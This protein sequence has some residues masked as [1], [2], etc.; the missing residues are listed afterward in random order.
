[1]KVEVD[2]ASGV[3][4]LVVALRYEAD[5]PAKSDARSERAAAAA[6]AAAAVAAG[7]ASKAKAAAGAREKE[8]EKERAKEREPEIDADSSLDAEAVSDQPGDV[9]DNEESAK[10]GL[11]KVSAGAAAA[12]KKA[13]GKVGPAITGLGASVKGGIARLMDAVKKRREDRAEQ[14]KKD[15]PRRMTAPPP[16]GAL[17]ADGKRLVRDDMDDDESMTPPPAKKNKKAALVGSGLGLLAVLVVF[18]ITRFVAMRNA[19]PAEPLAQNSAPALPAPGATDNSPVA[20]A[21][22][23][24]FGQTPLST[25]EPVPTAAPSGSADANEPA[26]T[27]GNEEPGNGDDGEEGGGDKAEGTKEWGEG[28]VKSPTKISVKLDGAVEGFNGAKGAMG[29]TIVLP[30]RRILSNS[31][32]LQKKDKR[33]ATFQIAN[34]P[35]GAEL[36]LQFKDGVPAYLARAKDNKLE[37][38]LGNEGKSKK[39]VAKAHSGKGSK[40]HHDTKKSTGTKKKKGKH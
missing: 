1:V 12:G 30:G 3:P 31:G 18:G 33:I 37:I 38:M 28:N 11:A 6:G 16:G 22:I 35:S 17:K 9:E 10:H 40:G 14:K 21:S 2:A 13:M 20:T 8:R 26:P 5:R 4:Q 7:A 25:T 36:T 23:P 32:E 15:A 24:L 34:K 39:A 29:F 27:A 19:I